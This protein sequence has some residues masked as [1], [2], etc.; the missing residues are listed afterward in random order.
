MLCDD[1]I[2]TELALDLCFAWFSVTSLLERNFLKDE[3]N[4]MRDSCYRRWKRPL[5]RR[6]FS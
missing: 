2:Y 6:I 1:L 5:Y 4:K 3:R